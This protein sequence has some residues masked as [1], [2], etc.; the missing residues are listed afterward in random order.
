MFIIIIIIIIKR[1]GS[2]SGKSSRVKVHG[3]PMIVSPLAR[4]PALPGK[5]TKCFSQKQKEAPI[6][7]S[8]SYGEK[9]TPVADHP[10][11]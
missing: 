7:H 5:D 9:K 6:E 4:Q 11:I 10:Y 3:Q 2:R 8:F 1:K